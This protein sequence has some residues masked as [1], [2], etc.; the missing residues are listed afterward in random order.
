[1]FLKS[2][3]LRSSKLTAAD[4]DIVSDTLPV[5]SDNFCT[6]YFLI[7]I[8]YSSDLTSLMS[9]CTYIYISM[10]HRHFPSESFSWSVCAGGITGHL[11]GNN[12]DTT[13]SELWHH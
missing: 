12:Y 13:K 7:C 2:S 4:I 8:C 11:H 1:M 3:V 10:I 9:V 5:V 6:Y